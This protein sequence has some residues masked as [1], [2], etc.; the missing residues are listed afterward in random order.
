MLDRKKFLN[1]CEECNVDEVWV[2]FENPFT[3]EHDKQGEEVFV[4]E[5]S[6][7]AQGRG[8]SNADSKLTGFFAPKYNSEDEDEILS[9]DLWCRIVTN[10]NEYSSE[11]FAQ[12]KDKLLL[13]YRKGDGVIV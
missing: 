3:Q 9:V 12:E 8:I 10:S 13:I 4:C 7:E 5:W 2:N 11:K 1:I 6:N